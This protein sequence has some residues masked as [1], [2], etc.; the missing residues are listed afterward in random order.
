MED[1]RVDAPPARYDVDHVVRAGRRLRWRHRAGWATAVVVAVAAAVVAP[2]VVAR[3]ERP[4]PAPVAASPSASAA[5]PELLSFDYAFRGYQAGAFRVLD[6]TLVE[7]R[8]TT[9][10]IRRNGKEVGQLTVLR[11]GITDVVPGLLS[12][13]PAEP[14]AG[15]EAT[16]AQF[17]LPGDRASD[18]SEFLV[19]EYADGA[20]AMVRPIAGSM[21]RAGMRAVAEALAPDSG[22][23][24]HLATVA[25]YL[26]ADY[27]LITA[28]STSGSSYTEFVTASM[29]EE[30][31]RR[32]G[33]GPAPGKIAHLIQIKAG[34]ADDDLP[35]PA[36][37]TCQAGTCTAAVAGGYRLTVSG[38]G[39]AASEVK[40]IAQG[41]TVVDLNDRAAWPR[42]ND[43]IP[44]AAQLTVN[45]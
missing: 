39:I 17:V 12:T 25:K 16:W 13:T 36:K 3:P 44:A 23:A 28:G 22:S 9:A 27:R 2:Q 18:D 14:V 37:L 10:E 31:M 15:R 24:A 19:W 8:G 32:P 38:Q 41:I 40:K 33:R 20:K 1:A 30:R 43:A 6:P 4:A 21:T 42:V 7:L 26:P 45:R 35:T 29:A 5:S 34:K 11:P